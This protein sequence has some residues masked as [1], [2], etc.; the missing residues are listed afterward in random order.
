MLAQFSRCTELIADERD[1]VN[2]R[3]AF[4]CCKSIIYAKVRTQTDN[5]KPIRGG[6]DKRRHQ[7]KEPIGEGVA[8]RLYASVRATGGRAPVP[9]LPP[10][11]PVIAAVM[12]MTVPAPMI[13]A[14]MNLLGSCGLVGGEAGE[15]SGRRRGLRRDDAETQG[16]DRQEACSQHSARHCV[17]LPSL[18][19]PAVRPSQ[20][21]VSLDVEV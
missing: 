5:S 19:D 17:F 20:P 3:F 1:A 21:P 8:N 13:T 11:A 7:K 9:P 2:R 12:M 14:P 6:G 16:G 10:T 18:F 4:L 15:R